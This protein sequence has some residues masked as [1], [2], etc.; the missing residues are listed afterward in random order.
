[1]IRRPPRSTR[2]DTLF[3]YTTLFRSEGPPDFAVFPPGQQNLPALSESGRSERKRNGATCAAWVAPVAR[4]SSTS[5]ASRSRYSQGDRS[6]SQ[7][8][9]GFPRSAPAV[10][11]RQRP[12]GLLR[13]EL[14]RARCRERRKR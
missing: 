10:E 13:A 7:A 8:V 11:L 12:S 3:P 5:E 1:M 2:T 6:P 14:H 9:E 4:G